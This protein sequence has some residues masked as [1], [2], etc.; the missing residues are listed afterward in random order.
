MPYVAFIDVLGFKNLVLNEDERE[1]LDS[2]FETVKRVFE[3]LNIQKG[4]IKKFLISDSIILVIEDG[5]DNFKMLLRAIQKLQ[6]YLALKDIWVR[7]AISSGDIYFEY[8]PEGE[9]IIYGEGLIRAYELEKKAVY[10]R[11]ILDPR[12]ITLINPNFNRDTFMRKY[13]SFYTHT[14]NELDFRSNDIPFQKLSENLIATLGREN[15]QPHDN[16]MFVSYGTQIIYEQFATSGSPNY[17]DELY[18]HLKKEIYQNYEHYPKYSW[19]KNYFTELLDF[20]VFNV[21]LE[22]NDKLVLSSE[23]FKFSNL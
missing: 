19:A 8:S 18:N 17:L 15:Y 1:K 12:L 20:I 23:I 2:F 11:V 9:Q 10:P 5:E 13:S 21:V 3:I 4:Q 7:G 6:A 22:P 16:D 14:Q